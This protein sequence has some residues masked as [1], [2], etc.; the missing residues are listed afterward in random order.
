M[1]MNEVFGLCNFEE[2]YW[3]FSDELRKALSMNNL[4]LEALTKKLL[5]LLCWTLTDVFYPYD[6]VF[7]FNVY[8]CIYLFGCIG[9]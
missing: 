7:F 6:T 4:K 8:L 5:I 2:T 3:L 1:P 9:S